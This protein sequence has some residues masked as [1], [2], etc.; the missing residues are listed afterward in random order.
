MKLTKVNA[1]DPSDIKF[2]KKL[3]LTHTEIVFMHK[4]Q[5]VFKENM[6]NHDSHLD[7]SEHVGSTIHQTAQTYI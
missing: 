6:L 4:I 7:L 5:S 3:P 2:T 1:D